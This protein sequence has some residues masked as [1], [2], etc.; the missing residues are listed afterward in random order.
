MAMAAAETSTLSVDLQ[1]ACDALGLPPLPEI[2][3][4]FRLVV[5]E[6]V[7]AV[8]SGSEISVRIV[9]EREIQELNK[10]YRDMD[11]P[12]N[13][14]A[15]PAELDALPGLP[16]EGAV[17]L[18]DLVLCAPVILREAAEQGKDAAAHWSHML[19]HGLLH[20]LDYDHGTDVEAER[21]ESLEVRI[22]TARGVENPYKVKRLN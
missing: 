13:V 5:G 21:M 3:E 22:L 20:L 17:L 18:G 7:T 14:L 10:T 19:V 6:S 9:G 1:I 8:P 4:W 2:A 15:F 12:T 16:Q 11:R